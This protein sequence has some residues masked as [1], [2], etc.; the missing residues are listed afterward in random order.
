MTEGIF[1]SIIFGR[2]NGQ[3]RTFYQ[4]IRKTNGRF[5]THMVHLKTPLLEWA[6]NDLIEIDMEINLN[7]AWCGDPLPI[8]A[9]FHYFQ[10]GALAAPLI[11]GGKPMGSGLS[12]FVIANMQEKHKTWLRGGRLIGVELT[13]EFREYQPFVDSPL[14]MLGVPGF[15]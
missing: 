14:S 4:I 9:E 12:M 2:V 6:G 5:G 15:S 3:I 11:V 10:E 8:L 1:G 13:I 7:A